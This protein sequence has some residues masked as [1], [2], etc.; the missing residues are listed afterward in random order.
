LRDRNPRHPFRRR[1]EGFRSGI[2]AAFRS[3]RDDLRSIVAWEEVICLFINYL[4][5]VYLF[6]VDDLSF[7]FFRVLSVHLLVLP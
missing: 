4:F 6:I 2:V 7:P 5:I 1:P 3:R